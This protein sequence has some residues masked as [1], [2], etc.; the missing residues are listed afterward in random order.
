MCSS[1][2]RKNTILSLPG[3]ISLEHPHSNTKP[4][5]KH[6]QVREPRILVFGGH[7][8]TEGF[9]DDLWELRLNELNDVDF[10]RDSMTY[11]EENCKWRFK[12][13]GHE[14]WMTRCVNDVSLGG[15]GMCSVEDIIQRSYCEGTGSSYYRYAQDEIDTGFQPD[16]V[17]S[18]FAL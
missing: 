8:D 12:G 11:R 16:H 7:D 6:Q 1:A 18:Y 10:L 4:T 5:L 13:E 15:T 3:E 17:P 14:H 2:K 9:L